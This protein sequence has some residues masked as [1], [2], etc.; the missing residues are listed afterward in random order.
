MATAEEDITKDG[1]RYLDRIE[2]S[3]TKLEL[4]WGRAFAAGM[5]DKN[6]HDVLLYRGRA[7][8]NTTMEL[9]CHCTA[10]AKRC[11]TDGVIIQPTG[12]PGR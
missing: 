4:V 7:L 6:E 8:L 2:E 11:G 12:G 3:F 5:I 9:H 1:S 10:I